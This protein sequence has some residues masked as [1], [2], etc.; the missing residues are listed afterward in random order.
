[1]IYAQLRSP[2]V[3]VVAAALNRATYENWFAA[4]EQGGF[5]VANE[6]EIMDHLSDPDLELFRSTVYVV[7]HA[8]PEDQQ[9]FVE[10]HGLQICSYAT[11]ADRHTDMLNWDAPDP[12]DIEDERTIEQLFNLTTE[13][14][15]DK[16]TDEEKARDLEI[17]KMMD[18][19]RKKGEVSEDSFA[20]RKEAGED[21]MSVTDVRV[22]TYQD[23]S[24][25]VD[26]ILANKDELEANY[27]PN[28]TLVLEVNEKKIVLEVQWKGTTLYGSRNSVDEIWVEKLYGD[29]QTFK[30]TVTSHDGEQASD[31]LFNPLI[32]N[33]YSQVPFKEPKDE[34]SNSGVNPSDF[35]FAFDRNNDD[36]S[37][38]DNDDGMGF[39]K[40][41][42]VFMITSKTYFAENECVD[43]THMSTPCGGPFQFPENYR[44]IMEA[45]IGAVGETE[46]QTRA[47]LVGMGF[48]ESQELTDL[49][50][51]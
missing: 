32:T 1:M 27:V 34:A 18:E 36:V 37:T 15:F 6:T 25:D 26:N 44:E 46:D 9:A 4:L 35:I 48:V 19:L 17:K 38:D 22:K 3:T 23:G 33:I 30:G 39:P 12:Y 47:T 8:T 43:S 45:T 29:F 41:T 5:T 21:G 7:E 40:G 14:R 51:Q 13:D 28:A 31:I 42:P 20:P 10:K 16:R 50:N 11:A 24:Q 49:L 2:L